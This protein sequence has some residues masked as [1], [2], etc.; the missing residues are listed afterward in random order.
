LFIYLL[1]FVVRARGLF[2]SHN[3]EQTARDVGDV[4]RA[5]DAQDVGG[6]RALLSV[7]RV[8]DHLKPLSSPISSVCPLIGVI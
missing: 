2:L 6:Q 4:M 7:T 3:P 1:Y 8:K 5:E